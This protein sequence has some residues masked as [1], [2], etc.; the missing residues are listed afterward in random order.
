MED[1]VRVG[2]VPSGCDR[3]VSL[4]RRSGVIAGFEDVQVLLGHRVSGG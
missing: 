3:I 4:Q 1:G 2:L